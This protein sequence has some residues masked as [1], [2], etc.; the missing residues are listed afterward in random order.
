MTKLAH[1]HQDKLEAQPA[2]EAQ[3]RFLVHEYF[4]NAGNENIIA[5]L[6]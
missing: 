5:A 6:Y 4:D 1:V 2:R 3:R